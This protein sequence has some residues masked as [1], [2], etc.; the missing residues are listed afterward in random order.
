[1]NIVFGG[2]RYCLGCH[3]VARAGA[4]GARATACAV[5]W[6]AVCS[7]MLW[8]PVSTQIA[9]CTMRSMIASA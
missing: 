4:S 5:T 7:R 8:P 2:H 6:P 9:L 1:M 3:A